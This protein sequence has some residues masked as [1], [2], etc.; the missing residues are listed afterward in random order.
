MK[1]ARTNGRRARSKTR[2]QVLLEQRL[3]GLALVLISVLLIVICSNGATVEE[4]D[5]TAVLFTLPLG[6]YLIF[7]KNICIYY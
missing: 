2:L 3:M 7:T 5:A 4:Q 1:N 6:L